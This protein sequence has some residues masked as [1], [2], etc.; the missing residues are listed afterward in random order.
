MSAAGRFRIAFLDG[1]PPPAARRR[2]SRTGGST[3]S[4]RVEPVPDVS[5][6][7]NP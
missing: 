1:D 6:V 3:R 5:D 7:T 4:G 2:R